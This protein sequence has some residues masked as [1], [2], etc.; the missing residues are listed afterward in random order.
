MG[1]GDKNLR[2]PGELG[3]RVLPGN[4]AL[5]PPWRLTPLGCSGCEG[6]K[7]TAASPS[8]FFPGGLPERV[9][10]WQHPRTTCWRN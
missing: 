6:L 9:F 8:F 1:F 4:H 5:G 10:P 2:E 3:I 7:V